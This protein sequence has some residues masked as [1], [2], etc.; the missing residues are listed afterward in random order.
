MARREVP[1]EQL[2]LQLPYTREEK[3]KLREQQ[4]EQ[5]RKERERRQYWRRHWRGYE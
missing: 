4:R 2:W 5:A 3:E 1:K